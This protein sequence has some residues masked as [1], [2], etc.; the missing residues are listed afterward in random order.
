[1][2]MKSLKLCLYILKIVFIMAKNLSIMVNKDDGY[3]F[4]TDV[5]SLLF[6]EVKLN[7]KLVIREKL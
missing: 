3:L 5:L 4:A 6:N 7:I 1:M 2:Q